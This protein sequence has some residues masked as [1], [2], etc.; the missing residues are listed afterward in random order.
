MRIE[1]DKNIKLVKRAPFTIPLSFPVDLAAEPVQGVFE[2][3]PV[4]IQVARL[5]AWKTHPAGPF[6][7][8]AM[9]IKQMVENFNRFENDVM[10]DYDHQSLEPGVKAVA[11]GWVKQLFDLGDA[12][13]WALVDWTED[14]KWEV[15]NKKFKYVS[16]ALVF[17]FKDPETGKDLGTHLD[18]VALTGRPF[19]DG[20]LPIMNKK[21]EFENMDLKALSKVLG[22][23]ENADEKAVLVALKKLADDSANFAQILA[24]LKLEANADLAKVKT[25]IA[26]L[27]K[28]QTNDAEVPR[29]MY[30]ALSAKTTQLEAEMKSLKLSRFLAEGEQLGK[31][32]PANRQEWI[33][34]F[35]KKGEDYARDL[36]GIAPVL[37]ALKD[38]SQAV[39]K[40]ADPN[41][42]NNMTPER[43]QVR[44][45]LGIS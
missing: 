26:A 36:L 35:D 38:F 12:G 5:G 22:L 13:L 10:V 40:E 15:L 44:E 32:V 7:I 25:T 3:V 45:Q 23:A 30:D 18:S 21:T 4:L 8:S 6:E 17:N 37:V 39:P 28:P 24:E 31:I 42:P 14:A 11:A 2:G 34:R 27:Q 19:I 16:P 20:M 33:E 43:K 29:A 1:C 9:D 41:D